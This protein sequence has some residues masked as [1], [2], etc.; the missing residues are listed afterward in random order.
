MP[1]NEI[2]QRG[3]SRNGP[4]IAE[5]R[6]GGEVVQDGKRRKW[7]NRRWGARVGGGGDDEKGE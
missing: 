4:G 3:I 2:K 7:E 5:S 6:G 1:I